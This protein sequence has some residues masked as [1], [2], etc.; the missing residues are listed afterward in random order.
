M[1]SSVGDTLIDGANIEK[2]IKN[3]VTGDDAA[4]PWHALAV[5]ELIVTSAQ[6][7]P[8]KWRIIKG[9]GAEKFQFFRNHIEKCGFSR[10]VSAV[11]D[12]NGLKIKSGKHFLRKNLKGINILMGIARHFKLRREIQKIFFLIPRGRQGKRI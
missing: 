7:F 12:R 1:L 5:G 8:H 6:I 10:A 4:F 2:K 9:R 3:V 11:E